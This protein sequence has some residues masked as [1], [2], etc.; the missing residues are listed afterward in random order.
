[1][2]PC[3]AT[4][5]WCNIF[6]STTVLWCI[7]DSTTAAQQGLAV[8]R[9]GWCLI[10][11]GSMATRV[12][13]TKKKWEKRRIHYTGLQSAVNGGE[14]EATTDDGVDLGFRHGGYDENNIVWLSDT[15][16]KWRNR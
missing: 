13:L 3:S 1:M 7:D 12:F 5:Q 8:D 11:A 6:D 15:L 10:R 4:V 2:C 14:I 9:Q 16:S